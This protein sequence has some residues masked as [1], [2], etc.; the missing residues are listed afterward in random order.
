MMSHCHKALKQ[1]KNVWHFVLLI[2]RVF[3]QLK[4]KTK[5]H[6]ITFNAK[7]YEAHKSFGTGWHFLEEWNTV[8]RVKNVSV[9]ITRPVLECLLCQ[10]CK[11]WKNPIILSSDFDIFYV[12][13]NPKIH[14]NPTSLSAFYV[15]LNFKYM[16]IR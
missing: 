14:K 16:K 1:I 10:N 9:S 8:T 3:L 7:K 5:I 6:L 11:L 4:N 15:F 13:W 12:F 2:P